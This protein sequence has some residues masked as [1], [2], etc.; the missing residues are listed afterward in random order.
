MAKI[1]SQLEKAQMEN[2]AADPSAG[3]IGRLWWN[4]V[5]GKAMLDD[6]T[7]NRALLRNDQKAILG[8][9]GTAADNIRFHRGA[10]GLLQL[11][12]A[13]DSTAEGTLVTNSFQQL[14]MRVQNLAADPA[15]GYA[16]RMFFNTTSS[17][18]KYDTGAAIVALG[19]ATLANRWTWVVSASSATG[20]THTGIGAAIT[21]ASAGDS[22]LIL[23]GTYVENVSVSKRLFIEGNGYDSYINGTWTFTSAADYSI[24]EKVRVATSI[25]ADSG[26][27]YIQMVTSYLDAAMTALVDNG[28]GNYFRVTALT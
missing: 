5:S 2:L 20:Y 26:A 11:V 28:T 15:A 7:N 17:T 22:I 27:D 8:N 1:Y 18:L 25:T 12:S 10:S 9:S 16:G 23:P 14:S 21:A 13:G 6:G 19:A 24:V 3:V 4:T